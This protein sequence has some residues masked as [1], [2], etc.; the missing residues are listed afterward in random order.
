[1]AR[2][3]RRSFLLTLLVATSCGG[4][5][6]ASKSA[7][8]SHD[9]LVTFF[10]EWRAFQEPKLVAGIPD[11]STRSLAAQQRELAGFVERLAAF[12]TSGW[13]IDQQVDYHIVRA[14]LNGLD[15]DLRVL[16]PWA[17]NPAFYVTVF[18][19]ESDQPAREGP[20][21]EG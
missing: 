16:K 15:F 5:P 20:H 11:Y 13:S 9:D 1:M 2:V 12:D 10:E 18:P 21:A 19:S 6:S 17:N 7:G 4:P 8:R 3:I 14:E